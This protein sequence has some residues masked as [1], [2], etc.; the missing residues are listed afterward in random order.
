[1]PVLDNPRHELF[2]QE[3]AKGT[4]LERAYELAGYS[5]SAKNA[6][7]LRKIEGVSSR[8]E[9]ILSQ[10]A[11]KAGITIERVLE[12]IAKIAFS[13][14][15]KVA[16]WRSHLVTEEDNPD[17]GDVLVVKTIVTNTVEMVA[18]E[19]IDDATAA[20]IAEIGQTDK[21]SV[22][23]K[24]HDK[25]SA[26]E[27][28]GKHLGMFKEKVELSGKDGGPLQFADVTDADRAKA[29]AAFMA[30]TSSK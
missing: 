21:G 24:L 18:S 1:M 30:K 26:L 20:A 13:D 17:G 16:K 27:K 29:L 7:R 5:P 14:I 9:E 3:V 2:A 12:E 8:I 4:P 15:R 19:D 28:L 25:L 11:E 10:S 6:A 23:I 22:K